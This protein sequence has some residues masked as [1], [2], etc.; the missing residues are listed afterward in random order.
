MFSELM[1]LS[2]SSA[3]KSVACMKLTKSND[4]F[5]VGFTKHMFVRYILFEVGSIQ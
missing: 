1:D 3:W 5:D 2:L 4:D